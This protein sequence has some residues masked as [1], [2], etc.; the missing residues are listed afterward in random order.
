MSE[1]LSNQ[2]SFQSPPSKPIIGL[3]PIVPELRR[4]HQEGLE[5]IASRHRS[6]VGGMQVVDETT[7]LMDQL[8]M[9][10]WQH[11]LREGTR[12]S[13]V[14]F[15]VSPPRASLVAIGG[16]GRAQLHPRSDVDILFLHKKQLSPVEEELIKISLRILWDV[17]L[18]IGHAVRTPAD[19]IRMATTDLDSQ[20]SLLE[21]RYLAGYRPLYEEY[22]KRY[23]SFMAGKGIRKF[24]EQ[25]EQ[26]RQ[27]RYRRHGD[28]IAIQEPNLKEGA[29]GLRDLHHAIWLALAMYDIPS[30]AGIRRRGLVREPF[31]GHLRQAVD[32][33]LRIRNELHLTLKTNSNRL[34][35]EVQEQVAKSFR[36]LDEGGNLA[37]ET[38][39]RDYYDAASWIQMFA[40]RMT[41]HCLRP[42][43]IQYLRSFFHR[44]E[45]EEGYVIRDGVLQVKEP[46]TFFLNHPERILKVVEISQ[47]TGCVF[48]GEMVTEIS[49]ILSGMQT[50][51]FSDPR[52]I[53]TPLITMLGQKG[54]VGPMMRGLYDL[55]CLDLLMPDFAVIRFLPRRDLYHRYTVDEHSILT[56]EI[57]DGLADDHFP[58]TPCLPVAELA[59]RFPEA[60]RK[61]RWWLAK[62]VVRKDGSEA[63]SPTHLDTM[64]LPVYSATGAKIIDEIKAVYA[65]VSKPALLYLATFLHD[66]GKGRGGDHH[67]KGANIACTICRRL[68]MNDPDTDLVI[69][70]VEKHLEFA[71]VAFRFDI[72]DFAVVQDFAVWCDSREKLD[73]LYLLTLADIWA[74]NTDLLTEWKLSMLHQFYSEVRALLDDRAAVEAKHA[75]EQIQAYSR[76]LSELPRDISE[77]EAE[78]H[79]GRMPSTYLLRSNAETLHHHLRLLRRYTGESPIVGCRQTLSNILE[80]VAIQPSRIGNF[81]RTVRPLS[82]LGLSISEA[83]IFVRDDAVTF[84]TLM[85]LY[86]EG[87]EFEEGIIQRITERASESLQ[88]RWDDN[89]DPRPRGRGG[90]RTTSTIPGRSRITPSVEVQNQ[91]SSRY[92]VI[93]VRCADSIGVL[94][95]IASVFAKY[96]LDIG[97]ARIHT[98][99]Q[100]VIDTF[101]VLDANRRKFEEPQKI[102]WLKNSLIKA[103]N[104]L[105]G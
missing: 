45:P 65:E 51:D 72:Q 27:E 5:R 21:N 29:G 12:N 32:F 52:Q 26:E 90:S 87:I 3:D 34:T 71:K 13:Q 100:R 39:M 89:W 30:L 6:G 10:I 81:M 78:R 40:D 4:F 102:N 96:G 58:E 60:R 73:Y 93:E 92:T 8:V 103:L 67:I 1:A 53:G 77:T 82:S 83:R 2:K 18:D 74:V 22:H 11:A 97:Y 15:S 14:D 49:R 76:F 28:T 64:T 24:I 17:G 79:L 25:K 31:Y 70:L 48:E 33:L 55:G 75:Q 59:A 44:K 84:T 9:R 23:R 41:N 7:G 20:T 88:D 50:E 54:K 35:F 86:Q 38:L 16:Y 46:E 68:G 98:E 80:V 19:C 37:E 91:A 63:E 42:S 99:G 94:V 104:E 66:I 56:L 62:P 85:V 101:F 61:W 105:M 47:Q 57:L 95:Q 43:R 69:F 36:Y